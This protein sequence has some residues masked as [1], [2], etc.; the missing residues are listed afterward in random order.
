MLAGPAAAAAAGV[1]VW[2]SF[3]PLDWWPA[4]WVGVALFA[5]AVRPLGY[6]AA[7]VAGYCFGL[8]LFVPM[9]SFLRGLGYDAW[10]VLAAGEALWFALLGLALRRASRLAG[11]PAAVALLWVAEEWARDRVPFGGFPWGRL[12]FG[13][14]HGPLLPLAAVGGAVLVTLVAAAAGALLAWLL[15][16]AAGVLVGGPGRPP[17]RRAVLAA[18]AFGLLA[19]G[20]AALVS[21]PTAGTAG[22]GPSHAVVAVVQGNVPRLGLDEFAQRRAVTANHLAETQALAADVAAGRLPAPQLVVWPENATDDDPFADPAARDM[23]ETAVA[24]VG[25]PIIVGAVLDGPGPDHVSNAAV[26]WSPGSGPGDRYV[27]QHLVP[28]GE[29]L[30]LR[31]VLSK[32]IGRFALIPKDFAAGDRPGV[33]DVG[34]ARVA[35][36]ICFEVADDT[37]VRDAVD[38]GGR[39]LVVQTNNATY[40]RVGDDGHGGETAQ[41]LEMSRLRAVEHGRAVVVAATSGVSAI[42]APDGRV[43]QRTGVYEAATLVADLP[44]RDPRHPRRPDRGLA[45]M[46]AGAAGAGA[47]RRPPA[48]PAAVRPGDVE[49]ASPRGR[50]WAQMSQA[51]HRPLVV[52]PTYDE[53]ESLPGVLARLRAAVPDTD[54]LVVDDASP[55]GTG[56]LADDLAA[57]DSR[58]HV[59]HRPGKAGLGAAY[60]AGF[61][62]ALSRD[63]D[64]VVEMDADGSH[65]PEQLPTLLAA[66]AGADLVL[67]SR[68][69]TGGSVVDWPWRRE[70]L[71]RGGNAYVRRLLGLPLRDATGGYRAYRRTVLETID[72][73]DVASAGYCF[74][75]DLAWRAWL[76]GFRLVEVPIRFVERTH[77]RSKMTSSIVTEA[78]W[79]VTVWGLRRPVRGRS[80]RARPGTPGTRTPGG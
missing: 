78:L 61:A 69:V 57:A 62:W 70:A 56:E 36:V 67:G 3:P 23:I 26:V 66:L 80:R 1:L 51:V 21:T 64:V 25:V 20:G 58:V 68:W 71:S 6:R 46:G 42:I 16:A 19:V 79:R 75:V 74:Q 45:G 41:Q 27:K 73:S 49:P 38:G 32:L 8:G 48:R 18:A 34:P 22:A 59:L 40:E 77:G 76:A 52:I 65:A 9:L 24:A 10:L 5:L 29:Y 50:G 4:A 33:L 2:T 35:D 55:D 39:L 31:S 12:A 47:A 37:V 60:L 30:P 13:Q 15:T 17:V 44:L 54:V 11:W 28:F 7:A 72:M 63:Y 43:L 14:A 53:R